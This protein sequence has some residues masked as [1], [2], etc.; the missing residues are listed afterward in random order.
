[1]LIEKSR[2]GQQLR[3]HL[4]KLIRENR[5]LKGEK[6]RTLYYK[7]ISH[8]TLGLGITKE[9][10]IYVDHIYDMENLEYFARWLGNQT[11]NIIVIKKDGY[12]DSPPFEIKIAWQ[13]LLDLL[14]SVFAHALDKSISMSKEIE[15]LPGRIDSFY[16]GK[17]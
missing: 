1:M 5:C 11:E 6:E 2:C 12:P 17:K 13:K 4:E 3:R 7:E 14:L 8:A 15:S 9:A 10:R 16:V